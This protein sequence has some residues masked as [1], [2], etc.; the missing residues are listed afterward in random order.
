MDVSL[1]PELL[2]LIDEHIRSGRYATADEVMQAGL[3]ALLQQESCGDFA[4]G[5][6]NALLA[7]GERSIEGGH[8]VNVDEVMGDLRRR[9]VARRP[10]TA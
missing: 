6:L 3:G 7:E 2:R 5:E 10:K 1:D 4:S 8:A 9:G